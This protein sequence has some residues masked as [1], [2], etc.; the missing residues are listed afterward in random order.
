MTERPAPQAGGED[1]AVDVLDHAVMVRPTG[2]MDI[3]SAPSLGRALTAALAHASPAKVVVV[4]C[5]RLVFCDSSALNTLLGARRT[6]V[7]A[8]SAIRLE[9][10]N[11]QLRSLLRMTGTLSLFP[12]GQESSD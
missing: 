5:S 1:I 9:S 8:G 6:A 7:E 3:D 10:P 2:E 12:L 4:D 11:D